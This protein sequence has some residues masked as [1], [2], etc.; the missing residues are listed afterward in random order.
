MKAASGD[1]LN[2]LSGPQRLA[3]WIY[4]PFHAVVLP[5]FLAI[6]RAYLPDGLS[7]VAVNTVYFALGFIFCIS[8]M[9]RFLRGAFDLLLDRLA[10][11]AVALVFGYLGYDLLAYLAAGVLFA[12]LGD[13][14][15]NPNDQAV[16]ELMN[17]APGPVTGLVIFIG[18]VVE[19]VLF[20]GVVFGS[21]RDKSRALAYILSMVIFSVCHIWQYVLIAMS[22]TPLIYM[23]PYI[24]AAYVLARTYEKT[25]SIWTPI[26]LHMLIN[27]LALLVLG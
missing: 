23:L 16:I 4:L 13:M 21:L 19:E 22:W 17:E 12:V 6:L 11:C 25:G 18:P 7:D 15:S 27:G 5:L 26:F 10:K 3:G 20:R 1:F 14:P 2:T 8:V 9:W 24:P